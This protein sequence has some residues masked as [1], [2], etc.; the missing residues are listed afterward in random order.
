VSGH[1]WGSWPDIDYCLTVTVL[2]MWGAL[3]DER[4]GLSFTIAAGPSQRSHS[5]VRA[6]W[7][8]RPYLTVSDLRLPFSSPPT[9][10]RVTVEVFE[11]RLHTGM[12]GTL[13]VP[14]L[15]NLG[16]DRIESFASKNSSIV[17]YLLVAAGYVYWVLT[18]KYRS[19]SVIMSQYLSS[20]TTYG[21]LYFEQAVSY[22][23]NW[24]DM[25]Q[26]PCEQ[27]RV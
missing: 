23:F 10:R 4:T 24:I 3:S 27:G 6:P 2:L 12:E 26:S 8:S 18:K 11:P 14:S 9:S 25:C 15:Y 17:A 5:R 22:T 13:L 20:V 7:N 1:I 21:N 16:M 19:S